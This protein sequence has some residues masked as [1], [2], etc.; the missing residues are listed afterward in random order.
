[1]AARHSLHAVVQIHHDPETAADHDEN[2]HRGKGQKE[3]VLDR[4]GF[5]VDV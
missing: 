4:C 5:Q 2:E 1:M 3:Q